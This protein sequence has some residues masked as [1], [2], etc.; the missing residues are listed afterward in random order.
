MCCVPAGAEAAGVYVTEHLLVFGA[1]WASVQVVE[2][3]LPEPSWLNVTVP[4]G[5]D[6][7]APF[8]SETVAVQVVDEPAS[9]EDGAHETLVEVVRAVMLK[10][11][12][13]VGGE[14]MDPAAAGRVARDER[15]AVAEL[16]DREAAERRDAARD[17]RLT[18]AG[19][20]AAARV[21]PDGERDLRRAVG[22]H[23]VVVRIEDAHRH[24]RRDRLTR[25]RVRR[26]LAERRGASPCPER[27]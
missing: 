25:D 21:R 8:V 15:V 22:R 4:S 6:A 27:R 18:A 24:G 14:R 17:S 26:L 9:T 19:Q 12:A 13:R 3:K 16:V 2:L 11:R 23:D 7:P 1:S 5:N 10:R 20:R